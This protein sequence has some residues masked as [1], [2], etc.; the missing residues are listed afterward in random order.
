MHEINNQPLMIFLP[1]VEKKT[2]TTWHKWKLF[3]RELK[4]ISLASHKC[5]HFKRLKLKLLFFKSWLILSPTLGMETV[6]LETPA[7]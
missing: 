4:T 7:L 3:R 5:S 2:L 1:F 6:F